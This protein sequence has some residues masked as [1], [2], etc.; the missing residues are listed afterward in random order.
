[1]RARTRDPITEIGVEMGVFSTAGYLASWPGLCPGNNRRADTGCAARR[2]GPIVAG[3]PRVHKTSHGLFHPEPASP[4]PWVLRDARG[5][6]VV[7]PPCEQCGACECVPCECHGE[8]IHERGCV[9]LALAYPRLDHWTALCERCAEASGLT[10]VPCDCVGDV[11][12]R[13]A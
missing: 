6:A 8:P 1:M 12:I 10:V 9:G 5:Y 4:V 3:M 11:S 7:G 13:F 2:S